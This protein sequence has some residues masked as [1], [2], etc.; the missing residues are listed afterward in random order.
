[1]AYS[2]AAAVGGRFY[3]EPNQR[4]DPVLQDAPS[5][6][7]KVPRFANTIVGWAA[8]LAGR[9]FARFS[10]PGGSVMGIPG[11]LTGFVPTSS[12]DRD[13]EPEW[14]TCKSPQKLSSAG[15]C[16]YLFQS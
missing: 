4:F 1:M 15:S 2:R 13:R 7:A 16:Y 11:G 9:I 14:N 5:T 3:A 12:G 6:G 8:G 10:K